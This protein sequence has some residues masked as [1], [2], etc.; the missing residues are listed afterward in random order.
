M[1]SF[2]NLA[3]DEITVASNWKSSS[4][5]T[6]EIAVTQPLPSTA[7]EMKLVEVFIGWIWNLMQTGFRL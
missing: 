3:E 4:G 6:L 1:A 5:K 7:P 2:H